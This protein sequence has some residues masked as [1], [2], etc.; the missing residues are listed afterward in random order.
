MRLPRK[1]S[2]DEDDGEDDDEDEDKMY[3]FSDVSFT[4]PDIPFLWL[5]SIIMSSNRLEDQSS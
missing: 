5:L 2:D 1:L 3:L 4:R